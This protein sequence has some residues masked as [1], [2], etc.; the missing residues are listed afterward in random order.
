MRFSQDAETVSGIPTALQWTPPGQQ[1]M[2]FMSVQRNLEIEALPYIYFLS[3]RQSHRVLPGHLGLPRDPTE[4][5]REPTGP[6]RHL[7]GTPGPL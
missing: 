1:V 2:S 3:L 4:P 5:S 7:P 6:S